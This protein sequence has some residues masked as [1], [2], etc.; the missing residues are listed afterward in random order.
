MFRE[1]PPYIVAGEI[2]RTSRMYA[3]SV[4]PL[5]KQMLA[6]ISAKLHAAFVRGVPVAA[7]E[8]EKP[9]DG[10]PAAFGRAVRQSAD[11]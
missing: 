11:L 9:R 4:S 10:R 5:K 2:V 1:N 7:A 6:T 3:R 8:K